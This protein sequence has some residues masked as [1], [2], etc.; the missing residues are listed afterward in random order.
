MKC[1]C[2]ADDLPTYQNGTV[3]DDRKEDWKEKE[4]KKDEK[5]KEK[6][7]EEEEKKTKVEKLT[8][9]KKEEEG[10]TVW[11]TIKAFLSE[12]VNYLLAGLIIFVLS[13][14]LL[15]STYLPTYIY[16]IYFIFT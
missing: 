6:K 12:Y 8:E 3:K 2:L 1:T 15:V 9:L 10:K 7:K 11:Q 14:L 13:S 5:E 4:E 16:I